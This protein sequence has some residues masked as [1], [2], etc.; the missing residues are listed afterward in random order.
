M[1]IDVCRYDY[2]Q[3]QCSKDVCDR[4]LCPMKSRIRRF[5]DE[6]HDIFTAADMKRALSERPVIGTIACVRAVDETTKTLEVKKMVGFK[7]LHNFQFEEK[8]IRV[9][10]S[11]GK[12]PGEEFPF[13]QLVSQSQESTALLFISGFFDFKDTRVYRCQKPLSESSDDYRDNQLHLC[14]C[15]E[16]G[17]VK[18]FPIFSELESHLNVGDHIIKQARKD[19]KTL[20]DKLRRNWVERFITAVNITEDMPSTSSV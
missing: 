16:P 8:G 4:I 9:W 1:G 14:E 5:C 19:S 3:P 13:D 20:Y 7:R 6:G 10:R 12:G 11:Y 2:S 18:R 17:C 15:W